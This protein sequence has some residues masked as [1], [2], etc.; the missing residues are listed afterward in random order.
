MRCEA[1]DVRLVAQ[2]PLKVHA[3]G[4]LDQKFRVA[5]GR[6]LNDLKSS[7]ARYYEVRYAPA[8]HDQWG[9]RSIELGYDLRIPIMRQWLRKRWTR[10]IRYGL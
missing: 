9:R 8:S 1:G 4:D 3:R 2:R 7:S 6:L 5:L 10:R